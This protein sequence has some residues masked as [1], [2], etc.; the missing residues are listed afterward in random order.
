MN[1]VPN[2]AIAYFFSCM[3]ILMKSFHRYS[4]FHPPNASKS[5]MCHSNTEDMTPGSNKGEI[6]IDRVEAKGYDAGQMSYSGE[7]RYRE[8][9]R[10]GKWYL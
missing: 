10:Q 3:S 5:P 6:P 7:Y 4:L 9:R 8:E 2:A 1:S